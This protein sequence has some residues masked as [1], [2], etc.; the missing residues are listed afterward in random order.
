MTL[1]RSSRASDL[2]PVDS[3]TA[4]GPYTVVL[5]LKSPYTPLLATL[6]RLRRRSCRRRS[7]PSSATTS[8]TDP[9][10]VGP[11][12]FDDRVAGDNIT[13]IKSPY[14]YDRKR[15]PPRQDRLQGR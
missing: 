7:W 15:R 11:F 4:S 3:V 8:A 14:Y 2:E 10:C 12:M 13:V 9:V 1:T 5:H 6:P